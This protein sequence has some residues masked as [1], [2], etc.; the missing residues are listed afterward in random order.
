[1]DLSV[2]IVA[3]VAL[4]VSAVALWRVSRL[5]RRLETRQS[6]IETV[7]EPDRSAEWA[8]FNALHREEFERALQAQGDR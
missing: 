4:V 7:P 5:A 1:M 6:Q 8:R 2:A 3:V